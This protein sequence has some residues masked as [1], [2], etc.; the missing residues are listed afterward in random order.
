M[1]AA[2]VT[3]LWSRVP[4]GNKIVTDGMPDGM[5]GEMTGEMTGGMLG[6]H[7]RLGEA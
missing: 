2:S 1:K 5:T 7:V 6:D 4:A 3:N